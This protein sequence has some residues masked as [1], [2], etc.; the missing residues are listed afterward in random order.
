V[1]ERNEAKIAKLQDIMGVAQERSRR[2]QKE[3]EGRRRQEE[4]GGGRRRQEEAGGGRE[5]GEQTCICSMVSCLVS[6][7]SSSSR[8]SL[9]S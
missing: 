3:A 4:A 7:Y 6:S 2:R 1:R 9:S 5:C 8:S